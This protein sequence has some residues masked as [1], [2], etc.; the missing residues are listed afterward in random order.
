MFQAATG[1][2]FLVRVLP[3]GARH[4]TTGGVVTDRGL[5]EF[6]DAD[7]A[8]DR[9]PGDIGGFGQ[10][11]QFIA[12]AFLTHLLGLDRHRRGSGGISLHGGEPAWRI[13]EPTMNEIRAWLRPL[14]T[15][16]GEDK[17]V[18]PPLLGRPAEH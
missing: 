14:A 6:Y 10:L 12:Q 13:D 15:E 1:K 17:P 8:D 9:Q 4:G 11:G 7:H 18:P 5:V 16:Y 3:P 2:W